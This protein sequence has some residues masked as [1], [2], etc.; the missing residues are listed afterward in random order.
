[1]K[2]LVLGCGEM[3]EEAVVEF[4]QHGNLGEIIIGTR[5]PEKAQALVSRLTSR[6]TR[7]TVESINLDESSDLAGLMSECDVTV[8]CVGPNYKYEVLVAKAAIKARKPLVDLNDDYETTAQMYE[9]DSA[10]KAAGVTVIM[11][12]GASP[13]INNVLVR[14]AAEELSEIEEIHTAWVMS[15]ADPGGLALSYHLLYSLSDKAFVV[16]GGRREVVRSFVDGREAIEFPPPVGRIGVFHIGH[17]EP[18]TLSRSFPQ[19][20]YIDDKASFNPPYVNNLILTLGKIVREAAG[21]VPVR[22]HYVE[23]MDFA[24]AYLNMVCKNL[25]NVPKEGALRVEVKGRKGNKSLRYFYSSAGR[26]AQG[27]GIPAAIGAEYILKG[28]ISKKGILAPEECIKPREFLPEL[29]RR[30]IGKLN[31]WVEEVCS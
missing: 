21:P 7:I 6:R 22:G 10:A 26:I 9:L 30:N 31:G 15:G 28:K 14:A 11:G 5:S 4:Y 24:A 3:G 1:M 17:P 23:P 27:T 2:A 25:L 13:G 16:R 20:D 29:L 12:L 19:A 18:I 8:N